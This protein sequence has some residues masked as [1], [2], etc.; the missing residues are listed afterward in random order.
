MK[1]PTG[2]ASLL[3]LG[4]TAVNAE[5]ACQA[6]QRLAQQHSN[7]MARRGHL[8]YAG[9]ERRA[10][11]GARAENVATGYSSKAQTIAQWWASP[12][13]AFNMLLPGCKAVAY[14]VSRTGR[15]YWA[16][17]IGKS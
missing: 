11:Q 15:Y 2:A 9:F 7:D 8:D 1:F 14:A 5:A 13:H 10:K 6:M 16:M 4:L 3:F 17:E 12:V